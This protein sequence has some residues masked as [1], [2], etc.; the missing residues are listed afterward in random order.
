MVD[1]CKYMVTCKLL[2]VNGLPT[3]SSDGKDDRSALILAIP[4]QRSFELSRNIGQTPKRSVPA[5]SA[6]PLY[7]LLSTLLSTL[8]AAQGFSHF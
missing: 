5:A 3:F 8:V 1:Q 7:S 4:R 2:E 6:G